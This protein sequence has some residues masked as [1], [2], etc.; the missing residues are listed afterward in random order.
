MNTITRATG[1]WREIL[2]QLGIDA[3]FL[4]NTHG[5]CPICGGKDRFRFD[6]RD[7]SGSYYCNQCGP[8]PGIMLIRK[9][10]GWDHKTACEAVDKIIGS[11]RVE[12]KAT[13]RTEDP[14]ARRRAIN[15]LIDGARHPDIVSAYLRRR[16]L[17]VTSGVLRGHSRCPYYDP[18]GKLVGHF[19]AV[20]APILGPDGGL[21]SAQRIYT[22]DLEPC[23]KIMPPVDTIRGA[24]VRLFAA[25]DELAIAEGV[26]TA[27]AVH[28]LFRVPVWAALSAGNLK[29]FSPPPGIAGLRI[30]A[31][32]D[33]N[34]AGQEAAYTVAHRLSRA[35]L[36]VE[37]HI[38]DVVGT[39]WL[40]VVLS[41]S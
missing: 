28:Q 36:S 15:R 5:P 37:V 41:Q 19:P 31:D 17:T 10:R 7:G 3:R 33:A 9:L 26:P 18:E 23:K 24:A 32:N 6:D 34:Y 14:E 39:D 30:F 40:D 8:G 16:G 4:R 2:P 13:Q 27:L 29:A 12:A 1:R 11:A 21:Q 25:E 22:I 38:P 20:I 35:G